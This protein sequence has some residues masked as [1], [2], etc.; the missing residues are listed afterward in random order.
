MP[1]SILLDF[2]IFMAL[3]LSTGR[4]RHWL[5]GLLVLGLGL[6]ASL[7]VGWYQSSSVSAIEQARFDHQAQSF[8]EAL[9]QRIATHTEVVRGVRNLFLANPALTRSEFERVVSGLSAGQRATGVRNVSFVRRVT[10]LERSFFE[11]MARADASFSPSGFPAFAIHPPGIRPEYL[12]T[13]YIWPRKDGDE[14]MGRDI[15]A[16]PATRS[17]IDYARTSGSTVVS[18]PQQIDGKTAVVLREPVFDRTGPYDASGNPPAA[19]FIGVIESTLLVQDLVDVL[20]KD[21]YLPGIVVGLSDQGSSR[22]G[23]SAGASEV[24]LAPTVNALAGTQPFERRLRV[25]DRTWQLTLQPTQRFVSPTEQRTPWFTALVAAALS[26]MLAAFVHFLTRQR[27]R[28]LVQAQVSDFARLESEDRFRA[29]FNQA[30]VGVA[31]MDCDTGR[32]VSV[33]QK[34]A[35]ILGYSTGAIRAQ[36][37]RSLIHPQDL[38]PVQSQMEILASGDAQEFRTEMRCIH[39]DGHEIWV[40]LTV[41][42]MQTQSGQPEAHIAVMQDITERKKM[43]DLLRGNEIRLRRILQRLP[44]G[45]CLIQ[46]DGFIRFRNERFIQISGYAEAEVSTLEQWFNQVYPEVDQR[47]R[48]RTLWHKV[49]EMAS[50]T[51]GIIP[52]REQIILCKDGQRRAVEISGVVLGKDCLVTMVDLSQRKAAEEEVKYLAFYDPLTGLPNRRLLIDRLQQALATSSRRQRCG[53][54]LLV[55]L[56]NFKTLNE[57]QGHDRGDALLLQVSQRLRNCVHEDD[58][59]ARQGGDEFVIVL[60]DL[61]DTPAQAASASEDVGQKILNALRQPYSLD[62]DMHH[63]SLSMGITI[64]SGMRETVDELLKRADLAMYKAKSSGRDTLRFYDP[65]MQA[66]VSARAAMEMDMRVG[67]NQSHFELFFQPLVDNGRITGA[68]A[69]LRWRHPLNGYVSPTQFIPLAEE[70]GLILPMGEWVM[71]NACQRLATWADHPDLK[72]MTLAVNV[73]PRQ[74]HQN[75]FVEQVLSAVNNAGADARRLKLELTE[76]LLLSDVEDTIAK[77]EELQQ[78]G[79]SFSLDDFGT[80]YS[81]LAYLKRLPLEQLKIDRSFVRD[82]LTDPNDAAIARTVVALAHSLGIG[83][84]A[85]GVETEAQRVFLAENDCH[86]W[87]G[88]LLSPPV[89]SHELEDLVRDYN[90]PTIRKVTPLKAAS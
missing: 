79:V 37:F 35:E 33:N 1:G 45:V 86:A 66:V 84:I 57:T 15:T 48:S 13:D 87:Q 10:A 70:S 64:F 7:G 43:E 69:L 56:D 55:D 8:S 80:G 72:H 25:H 88:F 83:V 68:E 31:Q 26:V 12:V 51:D 77:M 74:F 11:A 42:P 41:S 65:S 3:S 75:G 18:A 71:R 62:G 60:E 28:A 22:P 19:R 17:A 29:L 9:G 47:E 52:P 81:S 39:Q 24:L 76:S 90:Q 53:A 78:Y 46:G 50:K 38:P 85:E 61:G 34:Y 14:S 36:D 89:T 5:P 16:D 58:T 59:L 44:V 40:E 2:W 23:V 30:A 73:S 63:S 49:N 20:E 67:L 54:L 4:Y 6:M 21:G 82:V 32:F 27:S